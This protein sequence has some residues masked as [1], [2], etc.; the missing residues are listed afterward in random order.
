MPKAL[1][2]KTKEIIEIGVGPSYLLDVIIN[3]S[4]FSPLFPL[5]YMFFIPK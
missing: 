5:I 4:D 1:K 2:L 3:V